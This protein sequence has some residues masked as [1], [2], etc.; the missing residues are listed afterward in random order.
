MPR[1]LS[2]RARARAHTHTH[3]HMHKY[4]NMHMHTHTHTHTHVRGRTH[5]HAHTTRPP[6]PP[7]TTCASAISSRLPVH[8]PTDSRVLTPSSSS[9]MPREPGDRI[10]TC[11]AWKCPTHTLIHT[12]IDARPFHNFRPAYVLQNADATYLTPRREP[13][14][15]RAQ[16]LGICVRR[17]PPPLPPRIHTHTQHHHFHYHCHFHHHH[18]HHRLQHPPPPL[19]AADAHT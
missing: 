19:P 6:P 1:L 12:S 11:H 14:N 10:A 9:V 7:T 17:I 18:H 3:T 15:A 8:P 2:Y 13:S 16:V 5:T 4:M